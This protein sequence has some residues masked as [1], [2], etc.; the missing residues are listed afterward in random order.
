MPNNF[1]DDDDHLYPDKKY[2]GILYEPR[3]K[4]MTDEDLIV[5]GRRKDEKDTGARNILRG[6]MAFFAGIFRPKKQ[7]KA[8]FKK[9]ES[10]KS[11]DPYTNRYGFFGEK[12]VRNICLV[13]AAVTVV[14][15]VAITA[16]F[17]QPTTPVKLNIGGRVLDVETSA[18]TVAECLNESG[19]VVGPDDLLEQ[20]PETPISEDMEIIVRRSMPVTVNSAGNSIEIP[21]VSGTVRDALDKA[22]V[23]PEAKD[24]VYPSYE[25]FLRAGMT[26][27]H[28]I[29]ETDR[30]TEY[31]EIPYGYEEREDPDMDKGVTE[32]R[33]E[34]EMGEY[35]V[36]YE[37]IIKNG[38]ISSEYVISEQVTREPVTEVTYVGTYVP[39]P[40]PPKKVK[41][42]D[43]HNGGS[44][45]SGGDSGGSGGGS[46]GSGGGGGAGTT[47]DGVEYKYTISMETTAY[48]SA[49]DSGSRTATGTYPSWGTVAAQPSVLPYGTKLF[50]PGY[51]YGRV[52]DTGGFS[53]NVIDL[54]MGDSASCTCGSRWGRK[55]LTIYVLG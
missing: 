29:V 3:Q 9:A 41:T 17:S 37:Q 16:A 10:G 52:E 18:Q 34:G 8:V 31:Y 12:F 23:Y 24:E 14:S 51:G 11:R 46:G 33:Q 21:M 5:T 39:P 40:P 7:N 49:C 50:I 19:V 38:V 1:R 54:Y 20:N 45:G 22:G 36:V 48:C 2:K 47:P 53:S 27:E 4:P 15:T 35:E 25:T 43:I 44:G 6:V 13:C 26:I 55:N 28:I 42:S 32:V 30:R